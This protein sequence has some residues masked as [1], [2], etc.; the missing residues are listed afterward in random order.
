MRPRAELRAAARQPTRWWWL[1][2]LAA[3]PMLI[4]VI[5]LPATGFFSGDAGIKLL[6][7]NAFADAGAAWPRRIDYPAQPIDPSGTFTPRFLLALDRGLVAIFPYPYPLMSGLLARVLGPRALRWLPAA[8]ALLTALAAGALARWRRAPGAAPLAA[9]GVLLATPLGFYG[10]AAWGH[11]IASAFVV[12]AVWLVALGAFGERMRMRALFAA[13]LLLAAAAW[14]RTETAVLLVLAL[15]P[16]SA[17]CSFRRRL[18]GVAIATTGAATGLIG[19]AAGQY[20]ALGVWLPVH[21]AANVTRHGVLSARWSASR[22]AAIRELFAPDVWCAAAVVLWI[23]A[24]VSSVWGRERWRAAAARLAMTAVAAS[25]LAVIV[26]PAWRVLLLGLGP[27][28]AFPV[29]TVTAGWMVLATLPLVL[30]DSPGCTR[31]RILRRLVGFTSAWSVLA[32]LAISPLPGGYQWGGRFFL[33][34]A[35]LLCVL[36]AVNLHEHRSRRRSESLVIGAAIVSG[37]AV[38]LFGLALLHHVCRGNARVAQAF[39]TRTSHAEVIVTVTDYLPELAAPLWSER[40]M[41]DARRSE[42]GEALLAR[43]SRAGVDRW[44]LAEV[45]GESSGALVARRTLVA[46]GAARWRWTGTEE[47]ALTGR[48]L[49]LHRYDSRA[50]PDAPLLVDAGRASPE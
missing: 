21:I 20:A 41:L 44:T 30:L 47:L 15:A 1:S 25:L 48:R 18:G 35:V 16:L 5:T 33:P 36:L 10:A 46:E 4:S 13:G 32:Y 14:T 43:L 28:G 24:L 50:R 3:L 19:A 22:W 6:Q 9:T 34:A 31:E 39:A 2:I 23:A 49:R 29:R 7:A 45:V 40:V 26:V 17:A 37:V 11:A 42:D 38:Q 12:A 27:A 8:G